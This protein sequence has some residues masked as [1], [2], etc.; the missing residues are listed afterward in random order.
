MGEKAAVAGPMDEA[1]VSECAPSLRRSV[2]GTV[3][4]VRSAPLWG[5]RLGLTGNYRSGVSPVSATL[6]IDDSME[7]KVGGVVS[8]ALAGD[9][10]LIWGFCG[11]E[12]CPRRS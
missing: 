11:V 3:A 4:L 2:G 10:C 9:S 5:R 6:T 8:V 7:G 1:G 12:A